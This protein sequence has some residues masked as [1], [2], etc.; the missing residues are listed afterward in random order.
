MAWLFACV[1]FS[2]SAA[3]HW[4]GDASFKLFTPCSG[5]AAELVLAKSEALRY[6]IF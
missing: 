1:H 2:T 4:K 6:I 5:V 3:C